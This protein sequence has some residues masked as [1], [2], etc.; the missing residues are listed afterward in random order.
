MSRPLVLLTAAVSVVGAVS[1]A[2]SPIVSTVAADLGAAPAQAV[3]ATAAF[4]FATMGS[5]LFLAP[6]ADVIGADRA[7]AQ[8][9]NVQI[10]ALA[11]TMLAPGIWWLIAAQALCGIGAGMA[12]PAIYGLAPQMAKPGEESRAVGLVLSGWVLALTAGVAGAGFVAEYLGWRTVYALFLIFA[13]V[14]RTALL[15]VPLTAARGHA[16]TSPLTALK[17]PGIGR[18]LFAGLCLMLS[19]YGT[20][21]FLGAH[22]G[23]A[24]GRG[25]DGAGVVT[26]I[27][28]A[29]FGLSLFLDRPLARLPQGLTGALALGGL[30]LVYGGMAMTGAAYAALLILALLWGIVQHAGL[31]FVVSRLAA[32][33][34]RQRGA[35]MGLNSAMTYVGV[36][37]GAMLFRLP[38]E[39]GGL[40]ACAIWSAAI[41]LAGAVEAAVPRRS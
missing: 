32:L 18:G 40:A 27:Y 19:F 23:D 10:V 9:L 15:R 3:Q 14:L 17:V 41:A 28:G 36:T 33:D 1:M 38:Y 8:A 21:A 2:L 16:P 26:L 31:N 20:Y 37:G 13:V 22:V 34:A 6:R 25:S 12:L 7:L 5:A 24:L 11:L 39:A 35:I 30:A 29:G 4:G